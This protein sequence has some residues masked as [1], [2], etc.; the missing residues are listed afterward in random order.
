MI[1]VFFFFFKQKTAYE[2]TRRDWSS[3][4]CSSDL[5]GAHLATAGFDHTVRVWDLSSTPS[6]QISRS[7]GGSPQLAVA[8]DGR[9]IAVASGGG[10]VAIVDVETGT[11]QPVNL[12]RD[13]KPPRLAFSADGRQ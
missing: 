3:D 7:E 9:T 2:I 8:P 5:D 12:A 10:A 1:V 6:E 11:S 13:E 4:V